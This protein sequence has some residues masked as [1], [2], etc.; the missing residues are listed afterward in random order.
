MSK[1]T[2]KTHLLNGSK[3]YCNGREATNLK[4]FKDIKDVT[5][6]LCRNKHFGFARIIATKKEIKDYI[7]PIPDKEMVKR[8]EVVGKEL[9]EQY[10]ETSRF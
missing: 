6:L 8:A 7:L 3:I 2:R 10:R 4:T 9:E 5:C 1:G